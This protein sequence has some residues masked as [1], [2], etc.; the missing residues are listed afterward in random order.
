VKN[1]NGL[2][3]GGSCPYFGSF[4]PLKRKR[5]QVCAVYL[6]VFFALLKTKIGI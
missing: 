5:V 2:K 6:G 3:F 4:L 1:V